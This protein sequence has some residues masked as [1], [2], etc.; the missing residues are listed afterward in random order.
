M[1]RFS[2]KDTQPLPR[3]KYQPRHKK[4]NHTGEKLLAVLAG[5]V[6]FLGV[7]A[8]IDWSSLGTDKPTAQPTKYLPG[9]TVTETVPGNSSTRTVTATPTPG[10][11]TTVTITPSAT[12]A[13]TV[14]QTVTA[15]E[16]HNQPVPG[17]TKTVR[18][19]VT[20]TVTATKTVTAPP[21]PSGD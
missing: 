14:T 15:T 9:P 2:E 10:P 13:P 8:W 11:T 4:E 17:P 12:P 3:T 21:P 6:L 5:L 19:T 7:I 16:T 20:A 1:T 18:E